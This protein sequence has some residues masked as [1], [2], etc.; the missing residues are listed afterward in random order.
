MTHCQSVWGRKI[1]IIFHYSDIA[2]VLKIGDTPLY[3]GDCCYL[4]NAKWYE[5]FKKFINGRQV[6]Q[7]PGP[8][9]NNELFI[10]SKDDL[11]ELRKNL[12]ENLDYKIMKE[13]AWII[14]FGFFGITNEDHVIQRW[15]IEGTNTTDC[16]V[17][18]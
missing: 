3:K 18:I 17:E 5:Q 2:N 1:I 12:L 11:I 14:L 10:S 9:D 4:V 13:E 6:A 15:V 16:I 7:N 8:I